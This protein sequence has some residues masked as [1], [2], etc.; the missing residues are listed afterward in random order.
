MLFNTTT[1]AL[2]SLNKR[3]PIACSLARRAYY[4]FIEGHLHSP[5]VERGPRRTRHLSDGPVEAQR[6]SSLR[7]SAYHEDIWGLL[8]GGPQI[9][10]IFP[11]HPVSAV[12]AGPRIPRNITSSRLDRPFTFLP[13][14]PVFFN[15][16]LAEKFRAMYP[17]S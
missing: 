5:L 8:V 16:S 9:S 15:L 11:G 7:R 2:L 6:C 4:A 12:L 13:F 1:E 17:P 14:F 3:T 10:L